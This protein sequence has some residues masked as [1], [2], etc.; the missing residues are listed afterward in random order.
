M[1]GDYR[2]LLFLQSLSESF[3]HLLTRIG[4]VSVQLPWST[5]PENANKHA[6]T[7]RYS[8]RYG[9]TDF[10][11]HCTTSETA[12]EASGDRHNLVVTFYDKPSE[13]EELWL[14]D[15]LDPYR[16]QYH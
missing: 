11:Q 15:E 16:C 2:V 10:V 4:T 6:E 9:R 3:F 5:K 8:Q 12:C 7:S 1:Y 13:M 14:R